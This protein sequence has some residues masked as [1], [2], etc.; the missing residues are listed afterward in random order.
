MRAR[1]SGGDIEHVNAK[2]YKV[3]PS[4]QGAKQK[5]FVTPLAWPVFLLLRSGKAPCSIGGLFRAL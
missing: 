2:D 5:A 1:H 4:K 3:G